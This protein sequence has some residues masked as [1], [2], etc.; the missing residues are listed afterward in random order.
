MELKISD[1]LDELPEVP[2]D[3]LPYTTAS[4]KH[5]KELTLEKVRRQG[6]TKVRKLHT[7]V[8]GRVLLA[9]VLAMML[10]FSV[11]AATGTRFEDWLVGLEKPKKGE[12]SGYDTELLL[13]GTAY[14]WEV[15][16]WMIHIDTVD[17]AATGISIDCM[18]YGSAERTGTLTM[19]GAWWLEQ[20]NGS[21]YEPINA[22]IPAG[23]QVRIEKQSK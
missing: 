7:G 14:Y 2:V 9:A 17:A 13:G 4:E 20:W 6:N 10:A 16:N 5:I 3:I 12:Y 21:G 23:E 22:T 19:D 18:E 1:L 11:M 15:S 8:V